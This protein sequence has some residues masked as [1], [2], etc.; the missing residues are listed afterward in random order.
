MIDRNSET[1]ERDE[2]DRSSFGN[3]DAESQ[4]LLFSSK[5]ENIEKS[6]KELD[7]S[8]CEQCTPSY[9]LLPENYPRRIAS[10]RQNIDSEVLND[11]WV[12][13]PSGS[14]AFKL[15]R[16]NQYE[17]IL[18]RC[19]DERFELDMLLESVKGTAKKVEGLLEKINHNTIKTDR[20]I[21]IEEHFTAQNLRCI[22]RLYDD[23]GLDVMDVLRKKAQLD[24]PVI[25]T[26][27]KQK[28]EEWTSCRSDFNKIWARV[29]AK[30][31][32]KSLDHRS[33]YFK[34][35]DPKNLSTNALLAEIKEISEKK[36]GEDDVCLAIAAGNRRSI[37]P[38]ME[39]EYP[40]HEIHEDLYQLI[41]YSGGVMYN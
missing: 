40:D 11:D 33:F 8:N 10:Q 30:N 34:Q 20:P 3:K 39:F 27:L 6:I 28:Q 32:H 22:E 16:K 29:Y 36:R 9:R 31:H 25:L 38:N 2:L 4:I 13:V 23:H 15:M 21:C 19:E 37:I 35:Q 5:D 1:R 18:F 14:E 12:S 24:L 41:K 26:R 7:L 17:E